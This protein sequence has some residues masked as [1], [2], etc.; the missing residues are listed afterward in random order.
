MS[1]RQLEFPREF[2]RSTG[3]RAAHTPPRPAI[4]QFTSG[5]RLS[6]SRHLGA[7]RTL[8]HDVDRQ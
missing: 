1:E 6:H 8:P 3:G 5:E 2:G 4:A 7:Y